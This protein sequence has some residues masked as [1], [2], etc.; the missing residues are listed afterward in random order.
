MNLLLLITQGSRLHLEGLTNFNAYE[1]LVPSETTGSYENFGTRRQLQSIVALSE[2]W[3]R[4]GSSFRIEPQTSPNFISLP[5][6]RTLVRYPS[7]K[8]CILGFY[9]CT[10]VMTNHKLSP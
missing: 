2:C 8:P 10:K 7:P 3:C 4:E 9:C 5:H 1:G 6:R